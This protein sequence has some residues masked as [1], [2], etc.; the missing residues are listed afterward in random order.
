MTDEEK[1]KKYFEDSKDYYD[2]REPITDRELR[3][4]YLDGLEEGRKE[5]RVHETTCVN[6]LHHV[7][8]E[9]EELKAHCKAVDDINE[10]MKC[11]ENCEHCGSDKAI[12]ENGDYADYT[13]FQCD[14]L[15]SKENPYPN[16]KLA[17]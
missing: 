12:G 2:L 9:N 3:Q 16:W 1:A 14:D 4:I 11:C 7:E 17:E 13:C 8:K 10:K 5:V 6:R 15:S